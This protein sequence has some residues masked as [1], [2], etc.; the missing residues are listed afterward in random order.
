VTETKPAAAVAFET[1]TYMLYLGI[2]T[3][4]FFAGAWA[5][6]GRGCRRSTR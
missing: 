4:V 6:L 2:F 3:V 1:A 5:V